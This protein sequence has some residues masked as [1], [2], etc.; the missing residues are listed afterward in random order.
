MAHGYN[1]KSI[2]KEHCRKLKE[3]PLYNDIIFEIQDGWFQLV[4]DLGKKIINYCDEKEIEYPNIFQIKEKF[5]QLRFYNSYTLTHKEIENIVI[6]F[7][8]MSS[9]ICEICGKKAKT[10][11]LSNGLF[12][13]LCPEH[14]PEGSIEIKTWT[15]EQTKIAQLKSKK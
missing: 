12:K 2:T 4:Y 1:K 13:T 6:E 14:S 9:N 10:L 7:E 15:A 11:V 8:E 5:G 3:L